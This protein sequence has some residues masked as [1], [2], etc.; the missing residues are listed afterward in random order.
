MEVLKF[1]GDQQ[2]MEAMLA[3][4]CDGSANGT[5]SANIAVGEIA[6]PG[7]YKI[8]CS[9]P[10]NA[11]NV[12][13]EVIV[14]VAS[15]AKVMADLKGKRIASGPG[16]QNVG[17]LRQN[18]LLA[19]RHFL[20]ET[21]HVQRNA[22][23]HLKIRQRNGV[24]QL[25]SHYLPPLGPALTPMRFAQQADEDQQVRVDGDHLR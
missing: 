20:A 5:G 11:K 22:A 24:A 9:N 21:G 8:F 4:R 25:L 10:S 2:I 23:G 1:A 18:L 16:I 3:D 14:P 6:Q 15:T 19:P 13:D 17:A 12:L 7:T